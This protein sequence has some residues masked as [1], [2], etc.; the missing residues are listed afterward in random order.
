MFAVI[1]ERLCM[2]FMQG[3]KEGQL[4]SPIKDWEVIEATAEEAHSLGCN[5]IC[6][7]PGVVIIGAE[8]KRLIREI[9]K[10]EVLVARRPFDVSVKIP[11][12]KR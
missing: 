2:C 10:R 3:L 1:R 4:P 11:P 6:L 12:S 5:T 7:E 8:H 9:E